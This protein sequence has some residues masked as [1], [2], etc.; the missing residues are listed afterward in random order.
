MKFDVIMIA[1]KKGLEI[2]CRENA[3]YA[4]DVMSLINFMIDE[5]NDIYPDYEKDCLKI[6][7]QVFKRPEKR[8]KSAA[9]DKNLIKSVN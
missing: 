9:D 3:N 5:I 4:V 8:I 7:E 2:K 1:S 6:F